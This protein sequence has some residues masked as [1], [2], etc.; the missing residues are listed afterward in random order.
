MNYKDFLD[1]SLDDILTIKFDKSILPNK[2]NSYKIP[3][4]AL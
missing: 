2:T 1:Y 4:P 3:L